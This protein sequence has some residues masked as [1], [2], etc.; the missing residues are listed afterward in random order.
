MGIHRIINAWR[1]HTLTQ[2]LRREAFIHRLLEFRRKQLGYYIAWVPWRHI[3]HT[4]QLGRALMLHRHRSLQKQTWSR[5]LEHQAQRSVIRAKWARI[6]MLLTHRILFPFAM[7][8]WYLATHQRLSIARPWIMRYVWN[9][10]W[11][12]LLLAKRFAR[13]VLLVKRWK[14]WC[15][16]IQWRKQRKHTFHRRF[17]VLH[18]IVRKQFVVK[19]HNAL[20]HAWKQWMKKIH[21]PQLPNHHHNAIVLAKALQKHNAIQSLCLSQ[22]GQVMLFHNIHPLSWPWIQSLSVQQRRKL[23]R[24][25]IIRAALWHRY[26]APLEIQDLRIKREYQ[27]RQ[28]IYQRILREQSRRDQSEGYV[29]YMSRGNMTEDVEA[30]VK[31]NKER[32]KLGSLRERMAAV[33]T[34]ATSLGRYRSELSRAKVM[35]E[36]QELYGSIEEHQKDEDFLAKEEEDA[37]G[38]LALRMK[39]HPTA[40]W[41]S[42]QYIG[43]R[44]NFFE[45]ATS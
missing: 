5:W 29:D 4:N 3:V 33:L 6:P 19:Y 12:K 1:L 41:I 32:E 22:A 15:N 30:A 17:H 39:R 31:N 38:I 45:S 25:E 20:Q 21:S 37:E 7:K 27:R 16:F 8:Q 11:K 40:K 35:E 23:P 10:K 13:Y 9:Q 18:R 36:A 44:E 2:R 42:Q 24:L 14:V 34:P 28:R 26:I 43:L